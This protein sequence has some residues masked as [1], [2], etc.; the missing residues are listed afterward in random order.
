MTLLCSVSVCVTSLVNLGLDM[1]DLS[2]MLR[3]LVIRCARSVFT[4]LKGSSPI[5]IVLPI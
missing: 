5:F 1:S 4:K 3:S 2:D